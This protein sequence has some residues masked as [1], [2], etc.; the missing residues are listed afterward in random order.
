MAQKTW[1]DNTVIE[2]QINLRISATGNK[3]LPVRQS[4]I[5]IIQ[6]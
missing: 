6:Q 3:F 2:Y 1:L 5:K 4:S